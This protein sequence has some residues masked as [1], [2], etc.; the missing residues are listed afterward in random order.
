M[1]EKPARRAPSR[2]VSTSVSGWRMLRT[3]R[4]GVQV[5][6]RPVSISSRDIAAIGAASP[7]AAG[8]SVRLRDAF[9]AERGRR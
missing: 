2:A 4:S 9:T 7:G 6:G 3:T 5:Q 8:L 1:M